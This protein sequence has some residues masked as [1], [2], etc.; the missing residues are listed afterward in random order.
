VISNGFIHLVVAFSHINIIQYSFQAAEEVQ[1]I[2]SSRGGVT[3]V[4]VLEEKSTSP[5][6]VNLFWVM[7]EVVHQTPYLLRSGY[8]HITSNVEAAD[9]LNCI[10]IKSN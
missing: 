3:R 2:K 1:K 6:G 10:H 4:E 7:C 8:V 9:Q 5:V